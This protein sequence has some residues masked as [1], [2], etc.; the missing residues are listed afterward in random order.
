MSDGPQGV[1]S[2]GHST[3][4]TA[5]ICLAASWNAE[6]TEAAGLETVRAADAVA[7]CVGFND[8][9]CFEANHGS[10]N[11]PRSRTAATSCRKMKTG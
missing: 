9:G 8:P 2:A 4:Y 11:E 1:R 10:F 7:V 3:A 6:P 5:A